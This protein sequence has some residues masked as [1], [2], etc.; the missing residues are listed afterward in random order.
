MLKRFTVFILCIISSSLLFAQQSANLGI[1]DATADWGLEPE[2]PPQLGQYK[3]PGKVEVSGEGDDLVYDIYGNGDD[4]WATNDEGFFVYTEKSGTWSISGK[5]RWI[6]D[7]EPTDNWGKVCFVIREKGAVTNSK[8]YQIALRSGAGEKLG[9]G[10]KAQYRKENGQAA[11]PVLGFVIDTFGN[12]IPAPGE[13]MYFPVP[14]FASQH[15][16]SALKG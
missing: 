10:F 3:V 13:G 16:S 1:F 7:G 11:G 4:I 15:L 5:V 12:L 14:A 6:E 9:D 2:F 8:F